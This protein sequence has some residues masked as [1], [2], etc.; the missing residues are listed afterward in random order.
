MDL[1]ATHWRSRIVGHD[2]VD[3]RLL[4]GNPK[5]HR[6]HPQKQ[7]DVVRD[8]IAEFGF[9]KSV[10]V[11]KTTGYVIDGHERL[12]QALNAVEKD[13]TVTIDVEYVELSESEEAAVL[14]I[15]DASTEMAIVDPAKL[16][17]L[18][19]EVNTESEAIADMLTNLSGLDSVGGPTEIADIPVKPFQLMSWVLVGI[20][21]VKF[22]QIS[23]TIERLSQIDG[24]ILET[25]VSDVRESR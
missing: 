23:E 25:T 13:E 7:R 24:I 21:T 4:T 16:D 10:L 3:P 1:N 5:N 20:E 14:A 18:L 6:T 15:L 19:R 12:W 2:R 22:A 8:S 17:E 11:N 9:V